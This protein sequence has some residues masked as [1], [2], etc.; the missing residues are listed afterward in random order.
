MAILATTANWIGVPTNPI[1]SG[2]NPGYAAENGFVRLTPQEVG[3]QLVLQ[4]GSVSYVP[5]VDAS[6]TVGENTAGFA[7]LSDAAINS[8]DDD[9]STYDYY[10]M[11]SDLQSTGD[12]GKLFVR[13]SQSTFNDI[14][15][16][17]GWERDFYLCS[18]QNAASL[19]ECAS[20]LAATHNDDRFDTQLFGSYAYDNRRWFMDYSGPHQCYNPGSSVARCLSGQGWHPPHGS[21]AIRT[22]FKLYKLGSSASMPSP[23]PSPAL[24]GPSWISANS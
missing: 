12:Y 1:G 14:G 8:I 16:N 22:N 10:M 21:Y 18:S 24:L 19:S 5:T 20:W 17:M 9:S 3:W 4:Y 2:G 23:T 13:T 6:G 7:K 11:T 15:R